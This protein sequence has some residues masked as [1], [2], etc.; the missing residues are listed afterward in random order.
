MRPPVAAITTG[1][2]QYKNPNKIE[3]KII[4]H[5]LKGYLV[6]HILN[7]KDEFLFEVDSRNTDTPL[8]WA[9]TI[10]LNPCIVNGMITN[11]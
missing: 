8:F 10:D 11:S 6:R 2:F 7:S 4:L 3:R 5:M 1:E 9:F